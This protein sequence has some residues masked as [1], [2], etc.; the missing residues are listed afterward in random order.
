MISGVSRTY[1][2]LE[3]GAVHRTHFGRTVLEADHVRFTLLTT[4]T[5]PIHVD[6]AYELGARTCMIVPAPRI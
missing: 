4:N 3:V 2:E 1:D 6:A 5:N